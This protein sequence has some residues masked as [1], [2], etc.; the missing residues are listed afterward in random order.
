MHRAGSGNIQH[1]APSQRSH[2]SARPQQEASIYIC[3]VHLCG[4][5]FVGLYYVFFGYMTFG[6]VGFCLSPQKHERPQYVSITVWV[7]QRDGQDG[8]SFFF[9]VGGRR[10]I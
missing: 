5:E 4:H 7:Q 2:F 8:S 3:W 6:L 1:L 9:F 10:L